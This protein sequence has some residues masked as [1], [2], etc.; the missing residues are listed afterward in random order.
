[1]VS[2]FRYVFDIQLFFA[3]GLNQRIPEQ[4]CSVT[5]FVYMYYLE[6]GASQY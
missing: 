1:M 6:Y 5:P 3:L 2:G 4:G